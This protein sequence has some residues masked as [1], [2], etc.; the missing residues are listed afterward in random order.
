MVHLYLRGR[1][2]PADGWSQLIPTDQCHQNSRRSL[3]MA[4][5]NSLTEMESTTIQM[6]VC[7]NLASLLEQCPDIASST[8]Y[9]IVLYLYIYIALLAEHTNQKRFQCE[10]PRE[11]RAVLRERKRHM[12]HQLIKWIVLNSGAIFSYRRHSRNHHSMSLRLFSPGSLSMM[13]SVNC[14]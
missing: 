13:S 12:A 8:T 9:C 4:L 5:I 7:H 11:K 2:A 6:V 3:G 10:R 14:R 1:Q